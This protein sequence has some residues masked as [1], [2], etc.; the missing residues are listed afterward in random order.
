MPLFPAY[1][2]L[3]LLVKEGEQIYSFFQTG[4]TKLSFKLYF[5]GNLCR[6]AFAILG[7]FC[8][9]F[10][11]CCENLSFLPDICRSAKFYIKHVHLAR[12]F[13]NPESF[14]HLSHSSGLQNEWL[15]KWL[16]L[17]LRRVHLLKVRVCN[18]L[19][20]ILMLS[21]PSK[22]LQRLENSPLSEKKRFGSVPTR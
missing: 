9:F 4:Q 1:L 2:H 13:F 10:H 7:L 6:A 5:P 14:V 15:T 8:L 16:T 18:I 20:P 11:C 12:I 3:L 19:T 17:N 21:P 22:P